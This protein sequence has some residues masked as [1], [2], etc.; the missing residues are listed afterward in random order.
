M[1]AKI[2]EG[3]VYRSPIHNCWLAAIRLT[4]SGGEDGDLVGY[5][6]LPED[7]MDR[8]LQA[9]PDE[10]AHG[11]D[12]PEADDMAP[13]EDELDA[14]TDRQETTSDSESRESDSESSESS[15]GSFDNDDI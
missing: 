2:K 12:S 8:V 14:D 9:A 7:D 11:R 5:Y 6:P 3:Q 15:G 10:D 1:Y 13:G 4:F